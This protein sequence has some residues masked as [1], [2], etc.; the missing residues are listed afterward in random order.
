LVHHVRVVIVGAGIGGASLAL[1]LH[2]A[3]IT[4]VILLESV[5]EIR[6]LGVGINVLP[7]A[8]RELTELGLGEQLAAT[9]VATAELTYVNRKGQTIW[10]EPRGTAAGYNH[11]QYSIHRGHLQL[12]LLEA[13]AQR[14]GTD[15]VRTG[16]RVLAADTTEQGAQVRFIHEGRE[17]VE[18]ADVVIA[19]DGIKSAVRAQWFPDEGPPVWN[20]QILWRAVSRVRP[21]R[22]GRSMFM[23]GDREIKFVGYPIGEIDDDGLQL[24][25]WIAEKDLTGADGANSDWNKSVDRSVFAPAF[26]DWH[27]DWLDIPALIA[28]ADEVYEYP[29][30]DRPPL[31]SWVRGRVALLGD[32]AHPTYPI[33][34]NGSSQA[35]IDGRVLA[36]GLATRPIDDA[37]AFYEG[38]RLPKTRELQRV[39]RAM[40][41]E[42]VMQLARE[43]APEGFDDIEQVIPRS[44]LEEIASNYKRVAGFEPSMLNSQPTWSV[45]PVGVNG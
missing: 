28:A 39:N 15:A 3:G 4:D 43:R 24:I 31:D 6:P 19:A 38:E 45:D 2:A 26:A 34:S 35:I 42:R 14:L 32:A 10:T 8:V 9:G 17:S 11:P 25:N 30:V 29:M 13:V 37:L 40:G 27:Y 16:C 36:Y 44:E 22:T 7:H 21:F 1:S 23:A 33:G 20:G 5:S 18:T 41:P 12:L